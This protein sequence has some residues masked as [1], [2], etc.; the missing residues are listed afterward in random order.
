M[1]INSNFLQKI[2]LWKGASDEIPSWTLYNCLLMAYCFRY[3]MLPNLILEFEKHE[4]PLQPNLFY[5]F[6]IRSNGLKRV[7]L[8]HAPC[9]SNQKRSIFNRIFPVKEFIIKSALIIGSSRREE[10]FNY[11]GL[12]SAKGF[13]R[14]FYAWQ[15]ISSF[16]CQ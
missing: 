8:K 14:L 1:S 2:L 13:I 4:P 5:I 7:N 9:K 3:P 15:I 12:D 6:L 16:Y 10:C 11:R